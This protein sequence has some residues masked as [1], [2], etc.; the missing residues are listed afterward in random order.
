MLKNYVP[1]TDK[2][3]QWE[4]PKV[5]ILKRFTKGAMTGSFRRAH[6]P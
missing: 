3:Y 4:F 5:A 2:I 6:F 1:S